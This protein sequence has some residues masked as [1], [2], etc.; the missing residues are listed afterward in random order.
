MATTLYWL[1]G[2]GC[3]GDTWSLFSAESP[4]IPE[5]LELLS[6][7]LLWHPSLSNKDPD[8]LK[9]LNADIVSGRQ[10]LNIFCLEGSVIQGP[11]GSGLADTVFGQ[12]KKEL[13]AALAANA[14]FVIAVGTCASFGGF[15]TDTEA[16][17]I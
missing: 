10:A 5:L 8:R 15:G 11:S 7:D 6:I 3:G 9:E 4:D 14:D 12:P 16:D 2:G 1:Q 13:I 17:A